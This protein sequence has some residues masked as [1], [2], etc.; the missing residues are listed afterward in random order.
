MSLAHV[1]LG[2][3]F[4]LARQRP[5]NEPY[6]GLPLIVCPRCATASVRRKHPIAVRWRQVRRVDWA[7][8]ILL[9]KLLCALAI[10]IATGFTILPAS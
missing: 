2:C 6:Y 9:V 3:G 5:R 7:L 4:D 8:S 10:T 1:C